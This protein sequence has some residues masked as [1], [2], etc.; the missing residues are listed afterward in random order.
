M[1][2]LNPEGYPELTTE[3]AFTIRLQRDALMKSIKKTLDNA[4]IEGR[5][6]TTGDFKE[7]VDLVASVLEFAIRKENWCKEE[8]KNH[9]GL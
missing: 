9:W 4:A 8:L 3:Q 6:C 2:E 5:P 1:N 7:V